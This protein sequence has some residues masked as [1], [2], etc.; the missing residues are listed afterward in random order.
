MIPSPEGLIVSAC[1]LLVGYLLGAPLLI[2]LFAALPF[3]ST[4]FATLTAIG[5]SSPLIYTLFAAGFIVLVA[6]RRKVLRELGVLFSTQVSPWIVLALT[7]YVI[8]SAMF[9]PRLFAGQT[10]AIV[11]IDGSPTEL[12]LAPVSGNIT[13][14]AYFT[15]G[16]LSFFALSLILLREGNLAIV[17]RAFFTL[18]VVNASLGLIDSAGKL[19]GMAD[20]LAPIRTASYAFLTTVQQAGFWRIA[21]GYSEA[22]GFGAM[23]LVCLA[24]TYT[25][26]RRAHSGFAFALTIVLGA[27]VLLSTST[28]AYA[29]LAVMSLGPIYSLGR[30]AFRGQLEANDLLLVVLGA[31]FIALMMAVFIFNQPALQPLIDLF[32][33]TVLDKP[34]SESAKE[35]GY[36]NYK[37][38]VAF[39]D[40]GGVGIGM[41][42]SRSSSW[43]ISV[44]AQL[45]VV[46]TLAILSLG[47]ITARGMSGLKPSPGTVELFALASAVRASAIALLVAASIGGSG[48][49]PGILFFLALSVI[50][51]CRRHAAL[52]V[53]RPFPR[54][55]DAA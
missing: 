12:P 53:W 38:F 25:Y 47:W 45:G 2:G 21:G 30:S 33:A 27:L 35:R 34:M 39:M 13:Q 3:G 55:A 11:P 31:T 54:A 16:A 7:A 48:A 10:T 28:T 22:S 15:L 4:S 41:G 5:G 1:L 20:I 17:R 29:G 44:L 49:D 40:T 36:W 26:W 23:S 8:A 46:G 18:V 32:E 24:F 6:L 43:I 51:A 14:T 37:S 9:F 50:I 52:G 42:S 19:A